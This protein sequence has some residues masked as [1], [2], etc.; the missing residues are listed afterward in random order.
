MLVREVKFE[1]LDQVN[2]FLMKNQEDSIDI[3]NLKRIFLESPYVK[4]FKKTPFGWIVEINNEIVGFV[5]YIPKIYKKKDKFFYVSIFTTWVVNKN[6]RFTSMILLTEYLKQNNID[7]FINTTANLEANKIW[8]AIGAKEIPLISVSEV[9]FHI[10]N[11]ENFLKSFLNKKKIKLNIIILKTITVLFKVIFYFKINFHKIYQNKYSHK[12]SYNIDDELNNFIKSAYT[13]NKYF[14]ELI[15]KETLSWNISCRARK[16]KYWITKIYNQ[17]EVVGFSIC[18]GNV[19]KI[20]N[21]KKCLFG[22]VLLNDKNTESCFNS[23]I[24]LCIEESIKN[25]YDAVEFKNFNNEYKNHLKKFFFFKKKYKNSPYL[26]KLGKNQIDNIDFNDK[27]N[28]NVSL[29]DGDI[30]IK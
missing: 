5:G 23:L 24:K 21:F 2:N 7:L 12:I 29:L 1:D 17:K 16:N 27:N 20:D 19:N 6:Y 13:S 22:F 25:G 28:W 15:N 4:E 10:I 9:E 30:L 8:K 26:Y 11:V 18:F 3:Q 14:G